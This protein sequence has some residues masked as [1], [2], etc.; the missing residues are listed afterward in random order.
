MIINTCRRQPTHPEEYLM[1]VVGRHHLPPSGDHAVKRLPV[2][3]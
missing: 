2:Q 3:G 1:L